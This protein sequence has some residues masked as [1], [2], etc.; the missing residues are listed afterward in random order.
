LEGLFDR[1]QSRAVAS[2]AGVTTG[3]F[4][5]HF[6]GPD[7]YVEALLHFATTQ[8]PSPEF[9]SALAG[10]EPAV[11]AGASFLEAVVAAGAGIME[12]QTDSNT[13]ALALAVWARMRGDRGARRLLDNMHRVAVNE[14]STYYEGVL[15]ALG[16]EL[17]PPFTM[18]D[19]ARTLIALLEG[20]AIQRAVKPEAIPVER[21]GQLFVPLIVLMTRPLGETASA[22][23]WLTENA[24][25]WA[26]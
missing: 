23:Q 12:F 10:Y 13:F 7:E 20:L 18:E 9:A 21:L 4:Y 1:L 17:R 6:A 24:P 3:A 19:L 22:D 5:H 25:T 11:E 15:V 26:S 2:R 14:T 8:D 16:R